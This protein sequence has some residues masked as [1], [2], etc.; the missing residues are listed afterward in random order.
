MFQEYALFDILIRSAGP[1]QLE[2][3]VEG[4]GGDA[5]EP[6]V[7]PAGD[8]T[9]QRM[10]E[11]LRE[12]DT[13]ASM[14]TEIG[15]RLFRALFTGRVRDSYIQARTRLKPNQGLRLRFKIAPTLT[16]AAGLPWE[17]LCDPDSGRPLG[18]LNMAIVRYLPQYDPPPVLEAALPLKVLLTAASTEPK[19]DVTQEF[20]EVRAA[21]AELEARGQVQIAAEEHLTRSKLQRLLRQNFQIWHHIG[22]GRLSDDGSSSMLVLEDRKGEP[23]EISALEL[24]IFLEGS[25][26]QLIILDACNSAELTTDPYR[27]IA[28][29]LVQ[30]QVGAVVAMQFKAPQEATQPFASEFY[31]ALTE[32]FPIDACVTEGRKAVM[33]TS[34]LRNP[35]WGIPALYTRAPEGRLF[36]PSAAPAQP[37]QPANPANPAGVNV[38]IGSNNQ[39]NNSSINVSNIGNTGATGSARSEAEQFGATLTLQY[40]QLDQLRKNEHSL[41]MQAA[42]MGLYAPPYVLNELESA[43]Q[44]IMDLLRDLVDK[45]GDWAAQLARRAARDSELPKVLAEATVETAELALDLKGRE[46]QRLKKRYDIQPSDSGRRQVQS[47]INAVTA[48]IAELR[49]RRDT[50]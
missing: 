46:L 2:T 45:R 27:S 44:K 26:M 31:R 24:G 49:R 22:H 40:Q 11:R 47:Q 12:L 29:A 1:D 20:G 15:K 3:L 37:A 36:A 30:A 5:E 38:T 8:P 14:L 34:G 21:L 32:G 28:P 39:L 48:E 4:V 6:F 19:F 42:G 35:D 33:L 43:E 9:F 18:L 10:I 7:S 41:K 17:F 23:D 13:D 50:A 16:A 25:G